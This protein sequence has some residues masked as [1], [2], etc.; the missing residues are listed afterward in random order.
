MQKISNLGNQRRAPPL[1]QQQSSTVGRWV[2]HGLKQP[3]LGWQPTMHPDFSTFLQRIITAGGSRSLGQSAQALA[4]AAHLLKKSVWYYTVLLC[5]WAQKRLWLQKQRCK[6]PYSV[7]V[8]SSTTKHNW[9][10]KY[11]HHEKF[12]ICSWEKN[13]NIWKLCL[14][15]QE[16]TH[17]QYVAY[18]ENLSQGN[19]KTKHWNYHTVSEYKQS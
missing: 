13:K 14:L 16:V 8:W 4:P 15:N 18:I 17:H 3:L 11:T 2:P 7:T 6:C 9:E 5:R 12:Q 1:R 10:V 19:E